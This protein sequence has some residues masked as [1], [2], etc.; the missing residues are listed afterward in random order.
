MGHGWMT[1]RSNGRLAESESDQAENWSKVRTDLIHT[2]IY[3]EDS[4]CMRRL[5]SGY[6]YPPHGMTFFSQSQSRE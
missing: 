1:S 4:V 3:G 5:A 2:T 6:Y